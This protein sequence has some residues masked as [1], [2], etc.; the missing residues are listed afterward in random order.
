VSEGGKIRFNWQWNTMVFQQFH[1][2]Y[3]RLKRLTPIAKHFRTVKGIAN[4]FDDQS[5]T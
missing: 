3:D 1:R 4:P 2:L 5:I